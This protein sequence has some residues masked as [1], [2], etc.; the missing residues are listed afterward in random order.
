[1]F[2][3]NQMMD[4]LEKFQFVVLGKLNSLKIQI[5]KFKLESA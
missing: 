3:N 2:T 1:M 4:N 5:K